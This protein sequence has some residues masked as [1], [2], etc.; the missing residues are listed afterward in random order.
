MC[1]TIVAAE[2]RVTGDIRG[3]SKVHVDGQF[4]GNINSNSTVSVGETGC[5]EGDVISEKLIVHGRFT[6]VAAC[7]EIE[8][9]AGGVLVGQ[10]TADILMIERGGFF[11]GESKQKTPKGKI[12]PST[13]GCAVVSM[14]DNEKVA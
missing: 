9:K 8:I 10:I 6:G 1:K 13:G 5:I 12:H 7:E 14:R 3:K 11:E 2:T 4:S